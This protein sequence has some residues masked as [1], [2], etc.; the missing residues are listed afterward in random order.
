LA[1]TLNR[2]SGQQ[3]HKVVIFP[4]SVVFLRLVTGRSGRRLRV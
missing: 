2:C 1:L 3:F 4:V